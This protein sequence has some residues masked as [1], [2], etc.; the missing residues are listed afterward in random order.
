MRKTPEGVEYFQVNRRRPSSFNYQPRKTTSKKNPTLRYFLLF[1]SRIIQAQRVCVTWRSKFFEYFFNCNVQMHNYYSTLRLKLKLKVKL[2]EIFK[3]YTY[4]THFCCILS[5][6]R[7]DYSSSLS[8]NLSAS[9][10]QNKNTKPPLLSYF[11][12]I[13]PA[14]LFVIDLH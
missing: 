6:P 2:F 5:D 10:K 14:H 9:I 4:F 1:L 13:L 11:S 12:K 3:R 7:D 8:L